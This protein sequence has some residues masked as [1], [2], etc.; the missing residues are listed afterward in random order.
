VRQTKGDR[1]GTERAD[2]YRYEQERTV[3]E[4]TSA[5]VCEIAETLRAYATHFSPTDWDYTRNLEGLRE[6]RYDNH[7]DS[8]LRRL[9]SAWRVFVK[10]PSWISKVNWQV[11]WHMLRRER[12][13]PDGVLDNGN[14]ITHWEETGEYLQFVQPSVGALIAEWLAA[15]PDNSHAQRVAGEMRRIQDAYAARLRD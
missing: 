9:R 2:T 6:I 11:A 3:T 7:H 14:V 10:P 15:E 8:F 12:N 4:T 1:S 5:E 13:L